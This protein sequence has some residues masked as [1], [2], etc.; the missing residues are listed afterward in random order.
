MRF[1]YRK[2]EGN[3]GKEWGGGNGVMELGGGGK[4]CKGRYRR[5]YEIR[6]RRRV[7]KRVL[8]EIQREV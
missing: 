7:K 4:G 2:G 8:M 6:I 1:V 5:T 3:I